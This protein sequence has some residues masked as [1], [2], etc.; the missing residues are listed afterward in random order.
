LQPA[1]NQK[2]VLKLLDLQIVTQRLLGPD[3]FIASVQ[4]E[5]GHGQFAI[6]ADIVRLEMAQVDWQRHISS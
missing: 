5:F 3:H 1:L 6:Q 4:V 2:A